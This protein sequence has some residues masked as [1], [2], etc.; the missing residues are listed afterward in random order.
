MVPCGPWGGSGGTIFDDGCYS[1]IRQINV[2]RNVG[3]V[4]IRV[5]YACDEESIWGTRAGGA[6]GFKYDKVRIS[7]IFWIG[8]HAVSPF[9]YDSLSSLLI[10]TRN[11]DFAGYL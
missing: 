1:G 6:G 10:I 8:R 4:Y 11:E 2:S 7:C 9:Y 5:L 3:I